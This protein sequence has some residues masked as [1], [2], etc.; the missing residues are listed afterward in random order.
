MHK[1]NFLSLI[2]LEKLKLQKMNGNKN[3][4]I[5]FFVL[6]EIY[7]AT[8]VGSNLP[9]VFSEPHIVVGSLFTITRHD[10]K[11][12]F[13][14]PEIQKQARMA[15]IEYM[16][17]WN[18]KVLANEKNIHW[19]FIPINLDNH[20]KSPDYHPIC[21]GLNMRPSKSTEKKVP[22]LQSFPNN[23]YVM[24]VYKCK[25]QN[26]RLVPDMQQEIFDASK[27]ENYDFIYDT[28]ALRISDLTFSN[29]MRLLTSGK[30]EDK[31]QAIDLLGFAIVE[32]LRND[33]FSDDLIDTLERGLLMDLTNQNNVVKLEVHKWGEKSEKLDENSQIKVANQIDAIRESRKD[34]PKY[35]DRKPKEKKRM[36]AKKG[37]K[38]TPT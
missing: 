15:Q 8:L 33:N 13:Q 9:I 34:K 16:E 2:V 36:V 32:T 19:F 18:S 24:R 25:E 3:L 29:I 7:L 12:S 27:I 38:Q 11:G 26:G 17:N 35:L 20:E 31:K 5:T 28:K 21:I 1:N 23:L 10:I 14:N 4:Q 37:R 6:L 22:H 30:E